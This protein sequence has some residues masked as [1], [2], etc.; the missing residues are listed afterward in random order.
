LGR[1]RGSKILNHT[2]SLEKR[3]A[4][5]A[6]LARATVNTS[7]LNG[8]G[9]ELDDE[10]NG[11]YTLTLEEMAALVNGDM[12]KI[13]SWVSNLDQRHATWLLRCLINEHQEEALSKELPRKT[14]RKLKG[15]GR[16]NH[17]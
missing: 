17:Q 6:A 8:P 2:G 15:F 10:I 11:Y 16:R 14:I 3:E 1:T 9:S 5:L 12:D 4:I 7:L 13:E